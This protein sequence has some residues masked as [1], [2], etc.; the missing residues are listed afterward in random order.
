MKQL[1]SWREFR[2]WQKYKGEDFG[3]W[4]DARFGEVCLAY[5]KFVRTFRS[6]HPKYTKAVKNLLRQHGFV[7][8]LQFEEDPAQQDKLTTWIEQLSFECWQFE[9][10]TVL[11]SAY[12]RSMMKLGRS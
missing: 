9:W 3:G 4:E 8:S 5:N 7:R 1:R 10:S 12:S 6:K 2:Q 11:S